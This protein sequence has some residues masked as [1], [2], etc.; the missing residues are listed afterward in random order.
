M[1]ENIMPVHGQICWYELATQDLSKAK[2]F[3][4]ELLGWKFEQSQ[5]V[6]MEYPEIK[7]SGESVG[8][9]MQMTDEWKMSDGEFMPSHWMTYVSVEDVDKTAKK[10]EEFGAK[11]CIPPTDIPVG[12]FAVINDPS[13]AT[14]SVIQLKT[15]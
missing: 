11:V 13:G 12:R 10:V 5:A 1:S 8:G 7:V 4:S 2:H 3:Y 14:I 15:Q 6:E 9:M